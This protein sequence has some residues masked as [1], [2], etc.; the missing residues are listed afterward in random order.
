MQPVLAVEVWD[1]VSPWVPLVVTLAFMAVL[2]WAVRW[3]VK[4][5]RPNDPSDNT[6]RVQVA[7]AATVLV[8]IVAIIFALPDGSDSDLALSVVGLVV[9]GALAISSQSIIANAMAGLMLRSVGSFKPGDFIEVAGHLGRVSELDLFHTEIQSTDRDLITLPNS[10]MVNEPVRVVRSS[11][12]IVSATASIGYD[13]SRHQL[14]ELFVE[15]ATVSGLLEPFVQVLDLGDYSVS[16][17]IAGF[18]EDPRSLMTARSKLRG[19]IIDTLSEAGVEI[20]S[21]MYV[22]RRAA[23]NDP[24]LPHLVTPQAMA[25]MRITAEDRVFDKAEAAGRIESTKAELAEAHERLRELKDELNGSME[26]G[27]L[28]QAAVAR[29]EQLIERLERRH[30]RLIDQLRDE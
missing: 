12:T 20:M 30:G 26:S 4:R 13:V 6:F 16:Y 21:P 10:L 17:R 7:T 9:T 3:L 23:D 29:Q 8:G 5:T 18:L 27:P 28:V 24:L 11:G 25:E 15:A 22:A 2:V 14:E 19:A 1:R